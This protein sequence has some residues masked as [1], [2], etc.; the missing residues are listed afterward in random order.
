MMVKQLI[1][2]GNTAP[3]MYY[4][5]NLSNFINRFWTLLQY[6]MES[7]FLIG[8]NWQ[9]RA[10]GPA[11]VF[12]LYVKHGENTQKKNERRIENIPGHSAH[13]GLVYIS[14]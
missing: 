10:G 3:V 8:K 12:T 1:R 4:Y 9:I 7:Y 6:L 11:G 2:V 5:H 13:A 14:I